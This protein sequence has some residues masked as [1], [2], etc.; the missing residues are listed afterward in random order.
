[1]LGG[2]CRDF[3]GEGGLTWIGL[4]ARALTLEL[5]RE[6][7]SDGLLD[8]PETVEVPQFCL[9]LINSILHLLHNKEKLNTENHGL[10]SDELTLY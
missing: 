6:R 1:M 9:Q 2:P 7:L 8:S 5:F 3:S 4:H 10:C